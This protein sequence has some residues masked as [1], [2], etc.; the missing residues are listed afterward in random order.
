MLQV[1]DTE[2]FPQ[3]LGFESLIPFFRVCKQGPCFTA[4]E[5]EGGDKRLVE[6]EVACKA[7]G[8]AKPDSVKCLLEISEVVEQIA[9]VL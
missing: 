5:E 9:L 2:K 8:V 3:A 4:A 1:G 7:G 6:L